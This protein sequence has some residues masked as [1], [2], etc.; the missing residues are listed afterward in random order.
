MCEC[1]M[2]PLRL[3]NEKN[4]LFFKCGRYFY[5]WIS[6]AFLSRWSGCVAGERWQFTSLR[7]NENRQ[8]V[9]QTSC[10]FLIKCNTTSAVEPFWPGCIHSNAFRRTL[11]SSSEVCEPAMILSEGRNEAWRVPDLF[12]DSLFDLVPTRLLHFQPLNRLNE[13]SV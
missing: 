1:K 5:T 11:N 4:D 3:E 13:P 6:T 12:E 10:R 8:I 9:R 2:G 7:L